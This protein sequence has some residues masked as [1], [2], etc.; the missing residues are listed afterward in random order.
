M[1]A[2][3]EPPVQLASPNQHVPNAECD[4]KLRQLR[5]RLAELDSAA[6][7]QAGKAQTA[8]EQLVSCQTAVQQLG[9]AAE[10]AKGS[11][12]RC[13]W[14]LEAS[15]SALAQATGGRD[16]GEACVERME[17][18]ER[19]MQACATELGAVQVRLPHWCR[20]PGLMTDGLHVLGTL[21]FV[22]S[23]D[24]VGQNFGRMGQC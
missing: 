13:E 23:T 6:G 16:R 18:Q 12:S 1:L 3:P 14:G 9:R 19:Y 15:M 22:A 24:A 21:C 8:T 2:E 7:Q 4:R 10:D 11:H 17:Q 20:S 5:S